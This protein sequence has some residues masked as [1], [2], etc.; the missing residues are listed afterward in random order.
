M[1]LIPTALDVVTVETDQLKNDSSLLIDKTHRNLTFGKASSTMS[2]TA[3]SWYS[4]QAS[5]FFSICSAS[6][7]A[8]ASTAN[9]SASP[10]NWN[11]EISH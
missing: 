11:K 4:F 3:A 2:T 8:F 9:A 1:K 6:A 10:F 5:A 7:F